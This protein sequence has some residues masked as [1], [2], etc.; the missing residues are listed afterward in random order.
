MH[1]MARYTQYFYE[2]KRVIEADSYKCVYD[3]YKDHSVSLYTCIIG[4]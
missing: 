4:S 3:Q 1:L 2:N